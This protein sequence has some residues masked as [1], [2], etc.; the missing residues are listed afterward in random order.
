MQ[1]LKSIYV[2]RATLSGRAQVIF[3]VMILIVWRAC[4]I[5]LP[6]SGTGRGAFLYPLAGQQ[7]ILYLCVMNTSFLQRVAQTFWREKQ[8]Q[9]SELTFVFPNQRAGLFFRKYLAEEAGKTIFAPAVLTINQLF[10]QLSSLQLADN[11]DLLFRLYQV[12]IAERKTQETFDDFLFWGRMMLSD[13]NEVDQHLVDASQL[14]TNL[15][16]LKELEQQFSMLTEEQVESV[17]AFVYSMHAGDTNAFRKQFLTIW[18]T[19]LPIYTRFREELRND[20]LA[21][22]GMLH[23]EVIETP[24]SAS[25]TPHS[26]YIFIGFNALTGVEKA[27]MEQLRDSGQADFYWDYE[28]DWLR[29]PQNRASLFYQ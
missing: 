29:D 3:D 2:M 28:A 19:L 4:R 8:E 23:R 14:F 17:N 10:Q 1:Y 9:M 26:A 18:N 13:F 11:I 27:L 5:I 15:R 22:M 12:Y 25:L 16:D 20:G 24:H 7:K 6:V 21:Y